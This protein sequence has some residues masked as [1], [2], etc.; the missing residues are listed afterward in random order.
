[1]QFILSFLPWAEPVLLPARPGPDGGHHQKIETQAALQE[2]GEAPS[3]DMSTQDS[4]TQGEELFGRDG[5]V[6]E[7]VTKYT[8]GD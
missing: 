4:A 2:A 6:L 8:G 7:G 5:N 3:A 1:M